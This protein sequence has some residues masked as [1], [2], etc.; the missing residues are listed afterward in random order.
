MAS[1]NAPATKTKAKTT[2]KKETPAKGDFSIK[3]VGQNIIIVKDNTTYSRKFADKDERESIKQLAA[4]YSFKPT[5]K[6]FKEIVSIMN[7]DKEQRVQEVKEVKEGKKGKVVTK[8]AEEKLLTTEEQ[9]AAAK[10]LL[11]DNNYNVAIKQAPAQRRY[12]G[13]Y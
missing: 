3:Q 13:E 1:K 2:A 5:V 10:K 12:R 7:A 11:E 6:L 4:S 8:P 9:I